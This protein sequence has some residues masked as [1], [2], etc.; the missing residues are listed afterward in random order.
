MSLP[1]NAA[2]ALGAV[3]FVAACGGR[4]SQLE[5]LGV[6]DPSPPDADTLPDSGDLDATTLPPSPSKPSPEDGAARGEGGAIMDAS[7]PPA[8]PN[9]AAFASDSG[10]PTADGASFPDAASFEVCGM[11]TASAVAVY[12]CTSPD[13]GPATLSMRWY[14][15]AMCIT[16]WGADEYVFNCDGTAFDLMHI[17]NGKSSWQHLSPSGF[18]WEPSDVQ[19]YV[20]TCTPR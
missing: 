7:L 6:G 9:D 1:T 13:L 16:Q 17:G 15:S 20:L 8:S 18:A 14:G 19:P 10:G 4:M 2:M 5:S 11:C 12:D 3:M